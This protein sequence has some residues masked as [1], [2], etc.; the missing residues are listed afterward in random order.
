MKIERIETHI[1]NA[2]MRNWV[3]VKIITNEPGLMV[4]EKEPLSGI[5]EV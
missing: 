5:L 2:R 4:G 3:F 1:C